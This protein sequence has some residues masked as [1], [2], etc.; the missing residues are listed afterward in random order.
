MPRTPKKLEFGIADMR[1]MVRY[2]SLTG[3]LEAPNTYNIG[4]LKL[5]TLST[6]AD[7]GGIE[8]VLQVLRHIDGGKHAIGILKDIVYDSKSNRCIVI[9]TVPNSGFRPRVHA[10]ED[11]GSDINKVYL[12]E[13][14]DNTFDYDNLRCA[15]IYTMREESSKNDYPKLKK[16]VDG[17]LAAAAEREKAAKKDTAIENLH[18]AI[19]EVR[20]IGLNASDEISRFFIKESHE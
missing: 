20:D 12:E 6:E 5:R 2:L 17:W 7:D 13:A 10:G 9:A 3:L 19:R 16:K 15:V 18:K 11:I 4:S 14:I 8:S 1:S